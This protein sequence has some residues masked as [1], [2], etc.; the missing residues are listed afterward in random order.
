MILIESETSWS[1]IRI[2]ESF[3]SKNGKSRNSI[4]IRKIDLYFWDLT[5]RIKELSSV[6]RS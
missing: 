5:I 4:L 2:L 6:G 1:L 3:L